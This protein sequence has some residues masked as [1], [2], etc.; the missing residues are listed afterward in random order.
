LINPKYIGANIYNRRSFKLKH[1]RVNNPRQMW[2]WRDGA[3]E[4][5]VTANLFEQAR[6]IIESRH[7]HLSDED[8]LGRRHRLCP[9]SF[10][11]GYDAFAGVIKSGGKTRARPRWPFSMPITH[12]SLK[13]KQ[14]DRQILDVA[15]TTFPRH[16]A[17]EGP[18]CRPHCLAAVWGERDR[19]ICVLRNV[20]LREG[21]R[22]VADL[23]G[24][25]GHIRTV[26]IYKII[27]VWGCGFLPKVIWS[28]VKL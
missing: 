9:I 7:R 4:P 26:S 19:W 12:M 25:G 28:I 14:Y 3:F 21:H 2:I 24:K 22:M 15:E 27:R 18:R 23:L 11:D 5:I 1:K 8:L 13:I 6:A 16:K 20:C 17:A 10:M